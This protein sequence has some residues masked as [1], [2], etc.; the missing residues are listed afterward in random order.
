MVRGP[1]K[2]LKR[3]AAPSSWMLDKLSGTY[4]PRPSPGPHKLR[5][6]LPLIV[7]CASL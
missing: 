7:S 2:H 5:E 6:S 1:R 3:L 4:A